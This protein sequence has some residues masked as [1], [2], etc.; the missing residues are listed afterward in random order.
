MSKI[1]VFSIFQL[2]VAVAL[3]NSLT[4]FAVFTL[5]LWMGGLS[6]TA[7]PLLYPLQVLLHET[8]AHSRVERSSIYGVIVDND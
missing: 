5:F 8:G 2:H 7:L 6:L 3:S 4:L 1:A